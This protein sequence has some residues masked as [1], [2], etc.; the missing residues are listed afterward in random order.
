MG[1]SARAVSDIDFV[2]FF[3]INGGEEGI[4]SPAAWFCFHLLTRPWSLAFCGSN[5]PFDNGSAI[6]AEIQCLGRQRP[7]ERQYSHRLTPRHRCDD[8]LSHHFA[9]W[10]GDSTGW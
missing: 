2:G 9:G 1:Y 4:R 10:S 6:A 7:N 3:S 5:F 8:T